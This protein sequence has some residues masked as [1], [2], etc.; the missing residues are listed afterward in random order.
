VGTSFAS[1]PYDNTV[2]GNTSEFRISPQSTRLAIRA[3]ADLASSKVAGYFEM[4]FAGSPNPGNV[5][6]TSSSYS[7]RIRQ[8]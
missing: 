7:F 2:P 3:D 6:V 4:A 5:A 8:A 1:L